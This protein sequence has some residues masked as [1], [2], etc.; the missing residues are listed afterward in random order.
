MKIL[1]VVLQVI[2]VLLAIASALVTL[3]MF[4]FAD[5]PDLGKVVGRM[6]WPVVVVGLV[7]FGISATLAR[8][9]VHGWS[10]PIAYLLLTIP[11]VMLILAIKLW[12]R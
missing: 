12:S 3:F 5:S 1:L 2:W 6:F 9:P 10:I 11:P 7:A 8:N 4:A